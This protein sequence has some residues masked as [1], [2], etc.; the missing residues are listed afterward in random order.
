MAGDLVPRQETGVNTIR[1]ERSNPLGIWPT[2]PIFSLTP[3]FGLLFAGRA[4]GQP[5]VENK[6][7]PITGSTK[8]IG[9]AR[10]PAGGGRGECHGG[11][12]LFVLGQRHQRRGL[13]GRWRRGARDD[14]E[15]GSQTRMSLRRVI[16]VG[17]GA[18]GFFARIT[19][20]QT[21]PGAP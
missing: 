21:V 9:F 2:F 5:Y 12:H 7:A 14:I 16:V 15:Q 13:A 3:G 6:T 8:G 18:A 11:L 1:A 17:G 20:P 4:T 10:P 19:C